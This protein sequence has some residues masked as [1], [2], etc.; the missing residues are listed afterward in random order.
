MQSGE[1]AFAALDRLEERGNARPR[2]CQRC[3]AQE[4]PERHAAAMLSDHAILARDLDLARADDANV[5]RADIEADEIDHI[6]VLV[7]ERSLQ[8]TALDRDL[9]GQNLLSRPRLRPQAQLLQCGKGRD[10]HNDRPS[11]G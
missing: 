4:H 7:L 9:P 5:S 6:R 8:P 3:G 1:I 2:L 11:Y 10:R